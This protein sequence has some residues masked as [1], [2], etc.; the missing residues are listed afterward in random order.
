VSTPG[1]CCLRKIDVPASVPPVP[2]LDT[3]ASI[4]PSVSRQIA[5]PVV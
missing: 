5:G 1:F 2:E 3:N 4:R